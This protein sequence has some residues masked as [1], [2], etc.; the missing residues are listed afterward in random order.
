MSTW[1]VE[2]LADLSSLIKSKSS[3]VNSAASNAINKTAT[4]TKSKS[5]DLIMDEVNLSKD[6]VSSKM[7]VVARASPANLR[8]I[9]Q[10]SDKA[11][12]LTRYPNSKVKDGMRVSVDK[13]TGF[14]TLKNAFTVTN[15][16]YS[17]STGIAMRNR[18]A[19]AYFKHAASSGKRTG[20]KSR[21]LQRRLEAARK[22]P[23][24]IYVLHAR[25]VNQVFTSVRE[26][27]ADDVKIFMADEFLK[28]FERLNNR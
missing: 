25:S 28:Q 23:R 27:V 7:S 15:L 12:L 8:A 14:R 1:S 3:T 10:A 11:T 20:K 17:N 2:K 6:Y 19:A 24:G 18:D 22:N 21:K 5:I 16:S 9:I 13:G 4:F 26:N